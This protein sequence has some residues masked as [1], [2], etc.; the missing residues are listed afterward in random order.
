[1]S[2]IRT[3]G[4]GPKVW[5]FTRKLLLSIPLA[6]VC[7]V[8]GVSNQWFSNRK[9]DARGLVS[10]PPPSL[11]TK[12][13]IFATMFR[14]AWQCF[15]LLISFKTVPCFRDEKCLT[16]RNMFPTRLNLRAFP[17]QIC[18][19]CISIQ[20]SV[21]IFYSYYSAL[22]QIQGL[23]KTALLI[24]FKDCSRIFEIQGLSTTFGKIKG[25]FE[26]AMRL[27]RL[28]PS[29]FFPRPLPL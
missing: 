11:A 23:F 27:A 2:V 15:F 26:T 14:S 6:R 5:P 1:M 21:W 7:F 12:K 18:S 4:W 22:E 17:F 25:F 9:T 16:A 24:R 29:T 10:R 19:V 3:L 20:R 13:T 28:K 8:F